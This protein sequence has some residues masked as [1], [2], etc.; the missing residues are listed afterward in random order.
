MAIGSA[1]M[2]F[3]CSASES[4][5]TTTGG[6]PGNCATIEDLQQQVFLPSC[7]SGNCH[8]ATVQGG[9]LDLES[10]GVEARLLEQPAKTCEATLVVPGNPEQSFLYQKV[11]F[12]PP[13]GARMPIV[14]VLDD[15]A[16]SCL[17]S[18][19]A[20]LPGGCETCGGAGCVELQSDA[21]HCGACDN[22]CPAGAT[23]E[24]GSCVCAGGGS[25]CSGACVDTQSDP[26]NCGT[27]GRQC[28]PVQVCS[29]GDCKTGCDGGLTQCGSACIDTDSDP[30]HCGACDVA[31]GAGGNCDSGSCSCP[32]GGDPL[33]DPNNCGSCGNVCSPGQTCDDGN[34][35]CGSMSVSFA[36]A[37]VRSCRSRRSIYAP[38][39]RTPVWSTCWPISATTAACG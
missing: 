20:S 25:S 32:G 19:I 26:A 23:C 36:Q 17:Q 12:A 31:C 13:C 5:T 27:C 34:C 22:A 16:M 38:A 1:L 37:T 35:S 3:S 2:A 14:G 9:G 21:A 33:T 30:N 18:W 6:G 11:Q 10:P 4:G 28:P 39:S 8:D 29:L 15:D 7:V 24:Q